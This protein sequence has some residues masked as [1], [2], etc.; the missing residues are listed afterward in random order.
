M[1]GRGV[2]GRINFPYFTSLLLFVN[3]TIKLSSMFTK[4]VKETVLS[5]MSYVHKSFNVT[6]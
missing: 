4:L 2:G 1:E 3:S 5:P 6:R